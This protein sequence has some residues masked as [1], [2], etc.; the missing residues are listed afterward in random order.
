MVAMMVA[1][2]AAMMADKLV[3]L[4]VETMAEKMD[5]AEAVETDIT[6]IEI[7]TEEHDQIVMA[8][9]A[10]R[11]VIGEATEEMSVCLDIVLE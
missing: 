5:K 10:S 4:M 7:T 2:L 9:I 3:E 1:Y 6:P 11:T 8:R